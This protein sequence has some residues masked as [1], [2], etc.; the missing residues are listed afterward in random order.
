M[1]AGV[2]P[3]SQG[4]APRK[5]SM[6]RLGAVQ[7][8]YQIDLTGMTADA[9]LLEF[10][11]HRMEEDLEGFRL[12]ELDRRF[13]IDLVKGVASEP[14]PLDDMLSAVLTEDWPVERLERLL[15]VILRAGVYELSRRP[16]IP[17][18][19]I[20]AEYVDLTRDFFGGKEPGM[21]NGVL[22]HL[23]RSLRP[24]EFEGE[25]PPIAQPDGG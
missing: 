19:A 23:A 2:K 21:T 15:R 3:K 16:E 17:A 7:A 10:L 9:V 5:R 24:E 1:T 11:Q 22:D 18:R 4:P 12:G 14:E 25:A 20:I 8:L 6:A 13:F